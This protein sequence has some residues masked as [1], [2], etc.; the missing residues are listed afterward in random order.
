MRLKISI[1]T[2]KFFL[3]KKSWGPVLLSGLLVFSACVK[4]TT[5]TLD[6]T[7]LMLSGFASDL[8]VGDMIP[9][10]T[11]DALRWRVTV[12]KRDGCP[13]R[14]RISK[15]SGNEV[16]LTSINNGTRYVLKSGNGYSY[17][18]EIGISL[19]NAGASNGRVW[20]VPSLYPWIN[21]D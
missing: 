2:S 6:T 9:P 5:P 18:E 19:R 16:E 13:A 8:R 20:L 1:A 10:P 17:I 3:Y 7:K 4:L 14:L 12:P 21:C 15:I 11:Q